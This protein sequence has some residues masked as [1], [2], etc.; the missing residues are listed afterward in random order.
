MHPC[1]R[2]I[3]MSVIFINT[4]W[5]SSYMRKYDENIKRSKMVF[6]TF[7]IFIL[8]TDPRRTPRPPLSRLSRA[9]PRWRASRRSGRWRARSRPSRRGA[10]ARRGTCTRWRRRR[11][12]NSK[13]TLA[14]TTMVSVVI[15]PGTANLLEY[16]KLVAYVPAVVHDIDSVDVFEDRKRQI[17]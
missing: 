4:Y 9:I 2:H 10:T 15:V 1:V 3:R 7:Y 14:E 17:T 12:R 13:E 11:R 6:T 16:F 5:T 8:S